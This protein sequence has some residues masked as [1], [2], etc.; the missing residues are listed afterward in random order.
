MLQFLAEE[1]LP[2][3][4]WPDDESNI[5]VWRA[6]WRS[7]L[8]PVGQAISDSARLADRM[9]RTARDLRVQIEEALRYEE[10]SGPFT[11]LMGEIRHPNS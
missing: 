3:L 4:D 11:Q 10:G 1:R 5:E 2:C 9:A 8:T 6:R 7:G